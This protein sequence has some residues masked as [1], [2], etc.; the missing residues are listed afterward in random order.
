MSRCGGSEGRARN[1]EPPYF[2]CSAAGFG[3]GA[4]AADFWL[5]AATDVDVGEAGAAV[6]T[7]ACAFAVG[8]TAGAGAQLAASRPR[9]VNQL[10]VISDF[11]V[12]IFGPL[13]S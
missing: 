3:V 7:V 9:S 13:S 1:K 2:G 4:G 5:G 8:A 11:L 6:G 12:F 10:A